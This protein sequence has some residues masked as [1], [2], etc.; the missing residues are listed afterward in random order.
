MCLVL[1]LWPLHPH[2]F[3]NTHALETYITPYLDWLPFFPGWIVLV[4]ARSPSVK[5]T[6]QFNNP[7]N[8]FCTLLTFTF[9]NGGS[10]AM[11]SIQELYSRRQCSGTVGMISVS[12]SI[13]QL[14]FL[15]FCLLLSQWFHRTVKQT[16]I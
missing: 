6:P 4:Q 7:H 11:P 8:S 5:A 10:R 16:A 15:K 1:G 9:Q 13:R 14:M 2:S 3:L 12:A